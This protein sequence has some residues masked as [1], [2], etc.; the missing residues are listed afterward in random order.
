MGLEAQPRRCG[1]RGARSASPCNDSGW[2]D[3]QMAM[4][5]ADKNQKWFL[6]AWHV[7][8]GKAFASRRKPE[9]TS[10]LE[11]RMKGSVFLSAPYFEPEWTTRPST[12]MAAWRMGFQPGLRDAQG[13]EVGFANLEE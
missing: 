12:A 3:T 8:D 7:V 4:T 2:A 9:N 6:D 11:P 1:L 10:A 13:L 5:N